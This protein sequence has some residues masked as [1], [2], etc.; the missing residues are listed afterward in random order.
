MAGKRVSLSGEG[1]WVTGFA[2][3]KDSTFRVLLVNFDTNGKHSEAV[4][5]TIGGLTPGSYKFRQH[6]FLGQDVT[7]TENVV[8]DTIQ[9]KILMPASSILQ[10]EITKI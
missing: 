4:P 2:S 10:L 3:T 6:F 5:I 9:K 8:G 1:S 7:V